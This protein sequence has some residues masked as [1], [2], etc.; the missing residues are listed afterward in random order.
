VDP[1]MAHERSKR[2]P[3]R[4]F[5][6]ERA[7]GARKRGRKAAAFAEQ[8]ESSG[9]EYTAGRYEDDDHFLSDDEGGDESGNTIGLAIAD[10]E[11][12]GTAEEEDLNNVTQW[13][14]RD[15]GGVKLLKRDEEVAFFRELDGCRNHILEMTGGEPFPEEPKMVVEMVDGWR[16]E[17]TTSHN[18]PKAR[19]K[20]ELEKLISFGVAYLE[21]RDKIVRA[22][23][24]L[25][26]A[27]AKK[28]TNRGLPFLDLLQEG[29]IGLMRAVE[30]FE[31]ARGY[32]FSTYSSWWI[33]QGIT[34]ALAEQSRTIRVSVHVTERTKKVRR[35]E[36]ALRQQYE[37]D[38]SPQ[39]LAEAMGESIDTVHALL[40]ARRPTLSLQHSTGDRGLTLQDVIP[41]KYSRPLFNAMALG[42]LQQGVRN[43]VR[44]LS[45]REQ[46]VL[47]KRF[48][49]EC[50][51]EHT[52]EEV[53][54][55]LEVCRERARQIEAGALEKLRHPARAK[56]LNELLS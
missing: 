43:A 32:K 4:F 17:L 55:D 5:A 7:G 25:V 53:G 52:L 26:A 41:D 22:N 49:I 46:K 42:E 44:T 51:G 47:R 16:T 29:N 38:P 33:R 19:R 24:R 30:K 2:S 10:D 1:P 39:E 37:R 13:Y 34:R 31:V 36:S 3:H 15:M 23:L 6:A 48:G 27:I 14:L 45:E 54:K 11:K 35:I 50:E 28:Y 18:K 56:K 12:G 20:R 21:Q 8:M 9:E 40:R